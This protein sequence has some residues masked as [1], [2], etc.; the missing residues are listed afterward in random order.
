[1]NKVFFEIMLHLCR[2]GQENLREITTDDFEIIHI[3]DVECVVK[4]SD[5][6][7]K[8]HRDDNQEEGIM[9][10][11][12]RQN[13]PVASFKLY[14]SKLNPKRNAFFQRPKERAP[15][16]GPWFDNMVLGVKTL[17]NMMKK[18]SNMANL[19]QVYTNHCIRVT[20]ITILDR[21]GMEARHIM[22]VSGH[23]SEESIRSYSKTS[24]EKRLEMS[25]Y[26]SEKTS[27]A[28]AEENTQPS[29]AMNVRQSP[30]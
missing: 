22:S 4:K 17:G 21:C 2:R 16:T 19:S 1:M 3:K 18:L 20:C 30:R 13:C 15:I 26:L 27:N 9:K 28:V 6:L 29:T 7:T 12:G 14:T 11:T 8:N 25:S 5:E 23:M 10:A 24:K